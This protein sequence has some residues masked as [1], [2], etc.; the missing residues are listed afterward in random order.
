MPAEIVKVQV[1]LSTTYREH[2]L[3]YD[4]ERKHMVEMRLSPQ[5]RKQ[6]GDDVKGYFWG[7]WG[8]SG[9]QLDTRVEGQDW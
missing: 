8:D 7:S 6:L 2:G 5:V 4:R 3:V 9:W 1:P